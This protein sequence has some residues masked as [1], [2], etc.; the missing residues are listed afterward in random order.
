MKKGAVIFSFFLVCSAH[1]PGR[2]VH[3]IRS[4]VNLFTRLFMGARINSAD[5]A[6]SRF[7]IVTVFYF[8]ALHFGNEKLIAGIIK[9]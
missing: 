6:F 7:L 5:N 4:P 3:R 1:A 8:S 2:D 9:N